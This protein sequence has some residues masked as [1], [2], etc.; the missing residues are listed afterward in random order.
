MVERP[1]IRVFS[2]CIIDCFWTLCVDKIRKSLFWCARLSLPVGCGRALACFHQKH[3]F[4]DATTILFSLSPTNSIVNS[5]RPMKTCGRFFLSRLRSVTQLRIFFF[6]SAVS[7][8]LFLSFVSYGE[9]RKPFCAK[10]FLTGLVFVCGFYSRCHN[11]CA[12]NEAPRKEIVLVWEVHRGMSIF[13]F[14][15][16]SLLLVIFPSVSLLHIS[17]SMSTQL[18]VTFCCWHLRVRGYKFSRNWLFIRSTFQ[19]LYWSYSTALFRC[20]VI[21]SWKIAC[22]KKRRW[23][24]QKWGCV[25]TVTLWTAL[26][27]P[28]CIFLNVLLK[29]PR[30]ALN[31]LILFPAAIVFNRQCYFR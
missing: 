20:F 13:V 26:M 30:A 29:L 7:V 21:F 6:F 17:S 25:S 3:L 14:S 31:T 11:S 5:G 22:N 24:L 2:M 28:C 1:F 23:I 18:R 8:S 9:Q 4:F 19:L 27:I 16:A 12:V 10:C 15:I